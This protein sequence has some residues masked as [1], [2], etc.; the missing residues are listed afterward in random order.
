MHKKKEEL[1]KM[2]EEIVKY[3]SFEKYY[4]RVLDNKEFAAQLL[5]RL[6]I[7]KFFTRKCVNLFS[8][9]SD[10]DF[11]KLLSNFLIKHPI[12]RESKRYEVMKAFFEGQF[13]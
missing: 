6:A 11:K 1:R 10:V 7:Y 4:T 3:F 8:E 13:C 5:F 12:E 2:F 9:I